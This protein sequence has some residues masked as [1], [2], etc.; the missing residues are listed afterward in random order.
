MNFLIETH[1][2][3]P[4]A[5]SHPLLAKSPFQMSALL[6]VFD[7]WQH[8]ALL[9]GATIGGA[10]VGI[11]I[12]LETKRGSLAAIL[13]LI[14]VIIEPIFTL[15]LFVYDENLARGQNDQII[16]L[17]RRLAFRS[18]SD[19]QFADLVEKLKP[20]GAQTF[21]VITYW[22]DEEALAIANRMADALIKA[23]WTID[24]PKT[25]TALVGV[26]AGVW[27]SY[28]GRA[29]KKV[30]DAAKALVYALLQHEI[31]AELDA[32]AVANPPTNQPTSDKIN[33]EVG[34]K[35]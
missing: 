22:R 1:A 15:W 24:Q 35:P 32:Q 3:Q 18:L 16:S 17:Q 31:Y 29:D 12:L 19:A 8:A 25:F 5:K 28:D 20:T 10:L 33:I 13:V 7:D 6:G 34:I 2:K 9:G 26:E 14:G 21:Q 4:R 27:V 11:G 23:G 30:A